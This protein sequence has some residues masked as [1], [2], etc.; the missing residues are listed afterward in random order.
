MARN[1]QAGATAPA[2]DVA[3]SVYAALMDRLPLG[4]VVLDTG[5]TTLD[6]TLPARRLLEATGCSLVTGEPLR[7]PADLAATRLR[8]W[9]AAAAAPPGEMR[10][11]RLRVLAGGDI[12]QVELWVCW[13]VMDGVRVAL[14]FVSGRVGTTHWQAALQRLY[15]LT[16][17]ESRV[18]TLIV[19]G[20][21]P[22]QAGRTLDVGEPTIRTHLHRIFMKTSTTRQAELVRD[23]LAGP[24]LFA[25][26]QPTTVVA[27][28]VGE[29]AG[30][31]G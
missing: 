28:E 27:T 15:G 18:A 13:Q 30:D 25:P 1:G 26:L 29:A 3:R 8:K 9:L 22:E 17:A 14:L 16:R 6:A 4:V 21:T 12:A 5:G 31:D 20:F 10:L 19:S 24:A 11:G 7:L 2:R 23:I